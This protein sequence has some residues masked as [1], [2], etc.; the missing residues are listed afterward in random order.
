MFSEYASKFLTTSQ[1]RSATDPS[2]PSPPAASAVPASAVPSVA[3]THVYKPHAPARHAPPQPA[4]ASATASRLF[5]SATETL[6]ES[7]DNPRSLY[8]PRRHWVA[9]GGGGPR[10]GVAHRNELREEDEDEDDARTMGSNDDQQPAASVQ[11]S[12]SLNPS[13]LLLGRRSFFTRH[14]PTAQSVNGSSSIIGA[15][16]TGN[17]MLANSRLTLNGAFDDT[18]EGGGDDHMAGTYTGHLY[19]ADSAIKS[20][21]KLEEEEEEDEARDHLQASDRHLRRPQQHDEAETE[22]DNT[23]SKS[24]VLSSS[25]NSMESVGLDSVMSR[26]RQYSPPPPRL[27]FKENPYPRNMTAATMNAA[28]ARQF[29]Y[30]ENDEYED[31]LARSKQPGVA[32]FE[33]IGHA[34][35]E[36]PGAFPGDITIP[37]DVADPADDAAQN[38]FQHAIPRDFM[39]QQS[40]GR[41]ISEGYIPPSLVDLQPVIYSQ[42]GMWFKLYLISMCCLF[43]TSFTVWLETEVTKPI[44]LTDSIYTVIGGSVSILAFDTVLA[45]CVSAVWFILLK[46][47]VRPLLMLLIISIPFCLLGLTMYP[48]IMSYRDSWGGNSVQDRAM[49]WTSLVPAI[50]GALWVWFA[51]RSRNALGRAIGIVQLACK[52]L[53]ENQILVVLS[54]GILAS[55]TAFTWLW[56]AMFARVFLKGRV[57]V[58]SSGTFMW[59]LDQNTWALGAWYILM[60]LWTWGVFSGIQRACTSIAVSQWY[61]HRNELPRL[62]STDVLSAALTRS[63]TAFS[64]TICFASCLALLI[65]LPVLALPRRVFSL[66]ARFCANLI[67]GPVNAL[68]NPLTLSYSAI[69]IQPLVPS[70]R[71]ISNLRFIDLGPNS[72][73]DDSWTAY[74]LSK[75]LLSSARALTALALGFGAWVHAAQDVNGGSL[76]GYVV[77]LMGG[78]IGWVV[79]GATEGNLSMIVDASFVSFAIDQAGSHGGHCVEADQ[80]FGGFGGGARA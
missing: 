40:T 45:V 74:R 7:E 14:A 10:A 5:Y 9:G 75:M 24:D 29:R 11:H 49:R 67:P 54:L 47:C 58:G 76:Y 19:G 32:D 25:R 55:F 51:I 17:N 33:A 68:V 71:G 8:S 15:T 48:L 30:A 28:N 72:S 66:V 61:F 63:C 56:F 64:G 57:V 43:A 6:A 80:Q 3:R 34:D 78:A 12:Q 44:K 21:W 65:R 46:K 27:R 20:S 31:V 42:D 62:P 52:I 23:A 1:P 39:P 77:G 13:R 22:D 73:F 37:R 50:T 2:A 4:S 69:T 36:F 38:S 16:N 53:A 26:A 59:I 18:N 79:L 41:V 35:A 60:Y 70:S